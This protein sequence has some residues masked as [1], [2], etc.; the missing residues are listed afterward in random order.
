MVKFTLKLFTYA[1][2]SGFALLTILMHNSNKVAKEENQ[3]LNKRLKNAVSVFKEQ[4]FVYEQNVSS[5]IALNSDI[6]AVVLNQM[7]IED[8]I[9]KMI[10]E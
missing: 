8:Q 1:I 9:L 7:A 5:F 6:K 4:Q 2:L 10:G 3:I